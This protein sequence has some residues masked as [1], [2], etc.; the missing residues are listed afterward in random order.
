MCKLCRYSSVENTESNSTMPWPFWTQKCQV[1]GV[2]NF[3][4]TSNLT[5][6]RNSHRIQSFHS[7][8]GKNSPLLRLDSVGEISSDP[9]Q[10]EPV[11][12]TTFNMMSQ[13]QEMTG[14]ENAEKYPHTHAADNQ[15]HLFRCGNQFQQAY[16]MGFNP[17]MP[18]YTMPQQGFVNPSWEAL[19]PIPQVYSQPGLNYQGVGCNGTAWMNY[20][21]LQQNYSPQGLSLVYTFMGC[22]P[23]YQDAAENVPV[24]RG[25]S[26]NRVDRSHTYTK[27]RMNPNA[28]P[29]TPQ[30]MQQRWVASDNQSANVFSGEGTEVADKHAENL[31]NVPSDRAGYSTVGKESPEKSAAVVSVTLESDSELI[32]ID[33]IEEN[34]DTEINLKTCEQTIDKTELATSDINSFDTNDNIADIDSSVQDSVCGSANGNEPLIGENDVETKLKEPSFTAV[35]SVS[36]T[37]S[38]SGKEKEVNLGRNTYILSRPRLKKKS[39]PSTQDRKRRKRRTGVE[40]GSTKS[41]HASDEQKNVEKKEQRVC[42]MTFI[43]GSTSSDD[44]TDDDYG[45]GGNSILISPLQCDLESG[46]DSDWDEVDGVASAADFLTDQMCELLQP[47]MLSVLTIPNSSP[48]PKSASAPHLNSHALEAVNRKWSAVYNSSTTDDIKSSGA[49]QKKVH[50]AQEGDIHPLKTFHTVEEYCRRGPWE[51]YAADRCRFKS[52][53]ADVQAVI[54]PVLNISHRKKIFTD[55]YTDVS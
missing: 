14:M 1:S 15:L 53:I 24:R 28:K 40:N 39:K 42:G 19:R 11:Q 9:E 13:D 41:D 54:D 17:Y 4:V 49:K 5:G 44:D 18:A 3:G 37:S 33:N 36:P 48:L 47:F 6:H 8:S 25:P 38:G 23:V 45:I 22:Q 10:G 32:A 20:N 26:L 50:F 52:R 35:V 12:N 7:D 43:V 31:T 21:T 2:P 27:S 46:E 51:R 16:K 29:F 30:Y 55:R 34:C